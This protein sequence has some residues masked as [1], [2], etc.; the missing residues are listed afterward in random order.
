MAYSQT[1]IFTGGENFEFFSERRRHHLCLAKI[2]TS[3]HIQK[4]QV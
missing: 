4:Y 2:G 1:A 3:L